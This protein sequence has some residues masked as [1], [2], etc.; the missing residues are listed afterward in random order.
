MDGGGVEGGGGEGIFVAIS[1][2]IAIYASEANNSYSFLQA[3]LIIYIFALIDP[4]RRNA[5]TRFKMRTKR[6]KYISSTFFSIRRDLLGE[7]INSQS[8]NGA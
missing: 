1:V 5:R 3:C 2:F 8:R 7:I 4:E 6:T